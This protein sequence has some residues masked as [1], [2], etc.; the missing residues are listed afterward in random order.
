MLV[1]R[2][3]AILMTVIPDGQFQLFYF[4]VGLCNS[5]LSFLE[6]SVKIVAQGG[7]P[8]I[9]CPGY[10]IAAEASTKKP[11]RESPAGASSFT[12]NE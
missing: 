3:M 1:F 5:L 10:F 6:G 11:R 8:F 2:S 12:T 7:C 4:H 9:S